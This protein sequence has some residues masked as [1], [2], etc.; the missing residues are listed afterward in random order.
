MV[1]MIAAFVVIA[2]AAFW[3]GTYYQRQQSFGDRQFGMMGGSGQGQR[4]GGSGA[5][6]P[7]LGNRGPGNGPRGSRTLS[8][9]LDRVD[10]NKLTLTTMVGS[11]KVTLDKAAK[12]KLAKAAASTDL[13]VGSQVIIQGSMG[14]DGQMTA[15]SVIGE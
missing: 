10:G 3:G 13:K 5:G 2:A 15:K 14:Q 1:T 11:V 7:G 4:F 12:V 9:R 8:G 6:A